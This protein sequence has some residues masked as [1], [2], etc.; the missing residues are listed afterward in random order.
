MTTGYVDLHSHYI[1]AVDDGVRTTAGGVALLRALASIGYGTVVATPHIR[2]AMFDNDREGLTAAFQAFRSEVAAEEGLPELGL[3]AEHFFD[4]VVFDRMVKGEG[5]PYPGGHAAL[6]EFP[7]QSFPLGV[8]HRLFELHVRGVRT[9][10]AHPERYRALFRKTDPLDPLM[11]IGVLPLLDVMSL[12]GKYG[13]KPRS[14]AERMLEEGCYYAACSDAHRA[15]HVEIVQKGIERLV[16]LVGREEAND[17]LDGNPRR[18][19]D[20][21]VDT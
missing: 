14:A 13:R 3:G 18:I 7:E 20:G 2:T 16:K 11:E 5:I 6:V 15:E 8:E 1:P 9:V 21:T 17:M 10:L 19:L 4:D 12:T